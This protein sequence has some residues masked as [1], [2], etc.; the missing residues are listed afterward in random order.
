MEG[1]GLFRKDRLG[2]RGGGIALPVKEQQ[3]ASIP[4]AL[5]GD[6]CV[7]FSNEFILHTSEKEKA[8]VSDNL[9]LQII[10]SHLWS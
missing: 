9:L 7:N 8:Y 4:A 3:V 5:P 6:G 1:H 2:T 10:L